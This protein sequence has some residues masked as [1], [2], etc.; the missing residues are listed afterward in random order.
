MLPYLVR[1]PDARGSAGWQYVKMIGD[2]ETGW[3]GGKLESQM[4]TVKGGLDEWVSRFIMEE[5]KNKRY[6]YAFK[7]LREHHLKCTS[8]AL[9]KQVTNWNTDYLEGQIRSLVASTGY[10]GRLSIEF[11]VTHSSLVVQAPTNSKAWYE[12]IADVFKAKNSRR[13]EVIAA[14]WPFAALASDEASSQG[15]AWAVKSEMQF[16]AEWKDVLKSAVLE[17]RK[18]WLS[19]EDHVDFAMGNG[20]E[21]RKQ[22]RNWEGFDG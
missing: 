13:Y 4:P 7:Y 8:F 16:W 17:G 12:A 11:P 14:V 19:V 15:N 20:W 18:G 3:R 2:N 9:T 1:A 6:V 22:T 10:K 5:I 21:G